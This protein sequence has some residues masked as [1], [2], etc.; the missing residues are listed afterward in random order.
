MVTV[1]GVYG[2]LGILGGIFI[3]GIEEVVRRGK[4]SAKA[5]QLIS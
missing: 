3:L 5:N 2:H 1:L 4:C